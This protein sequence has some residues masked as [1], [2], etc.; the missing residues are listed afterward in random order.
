MLTSGNSP[1]SW[2]ST[3]PM[4]SNCPAGCALP[5]LR[6]S[7]TTLTWGRGGSKN[8]TRYFPIWT[9]SPLIR[10]ASSMRSWLT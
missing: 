7:A 4:L 2:A 3:A 10:G 8:T 9:S 6:T 5:D 1:R